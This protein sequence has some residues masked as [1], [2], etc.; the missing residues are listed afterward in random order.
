M[1]SAALKSLKL[2][3]DVGAPAFNMKMYQKARMCT[4]CFSAF[5][6][7]VI[8]CQL[9]TPPRLK[10]N[11]ICCP[12]LAKLVRSVQVVVGKD[13]RRTGHTFTCCSHGH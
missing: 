5:C 13:E 8:S 9:P 1:A 10:S 3:E 4:S 6:R 11:C 7:N 12:Q 2:G